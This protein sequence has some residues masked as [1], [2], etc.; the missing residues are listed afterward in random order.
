MSVPLDEKHVTDSKSETIPALHPSRIESI[1]FVSYKPPPLDTSDQA[2]YGEW[3]E[4]LQFIAEDLHQLLQQPHDIFW[5]QVVFDEKIHLLLDSYLRYAPR[6]FDVV[7]RLDLPDR[8]KEK[9]NEVHRLIFLTLLRMATHK[10]SKE[11]LITPKIFGDI[12]YE[13]FLFDVPKMLDMSILY[14]RGNSQ[15]LS[16]M[17]NNIFTQQPKYEDDLRATVPTI[18]HVFDNVIAKCRLDNENSATEPKKLGKGESADTLVTIATSDFQ[19]ILFYLTDIGET[20]AS[21]MEIYPKACQIFHEFSFEQ[22]LANFYEQVI[23]ELAE[24]VKERTFDDISHRHLM[25]QKLHQSKGSLKKIFNLIITHTCIQPI[26]EHNKKESEPYVEDFLHTMTSVLGERR[27]LA[28]YESSYSFQDIMDIFDQSECSVDEERLHYIKN[29][30]N[31]AFATFGKRKK[32]SGATTTGG[33][34][35]PDG[36]PGPPDDQGAMG[37][38]YGVQIILILLQERCTATG[39]SVSPIELDSMI[40]AV[41]DLLPDLGEGFIEIALEELS[42]NVERVINCILEEKLPPSLIE[43]D[44][45][46]PRQMAA[47]EPELLVETRRNIYDGDEFDIFRNDKIDMSKIH[48]GKKEEKAVFR[49]KNLIKELK[50]TYDAYGSMYVEN[51]YDKNVEYDDLYED[52]Y[53]DTYDT[54][55][56]GADDADSADELMSKRL[57][58]RTDRVLQGKEDDDD[59]NAERDAGPSTHPD[60]WKK[61]QFV[62]DPAKLREAAA[63]RYA[64]KVA[65][66]GGGQPRKYDVQGQA[67]GQGQSGDVLKNRAYKE[68]HKTARAN[69]NRR[70]MSDRKRR[71]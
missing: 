52:E 36:S 49:D 35:S 20:L 65:R 51:M 59:D 40:I 26:L 31:T 16:K 57:Q 1:N 63:Q 48:K 32:P 39:A 3:M 21:F 71:V 15:I 62:A 11:N 4:R 37:G 17:V 61:N 41:K 18:L 38:A 25:K 67:K 60:G 58:F 47:P 23:P 54:N 53:D 66:R 43:I 69:H 55:N 50:P 34:T 42:Y 30:V 9:Q 7:Y 27:F 33:R 24:A 12:L 64:A 46:L 28:D 22:K 68:K 14:G 19:D 70:D 29:A 10:E 2:Q 45:T 6:S 56:V 8:Y 44:R 13:N 5:C